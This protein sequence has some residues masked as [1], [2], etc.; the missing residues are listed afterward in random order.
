VITT[1]HA[2]FP[3]GNRRGA[4]LLVAA[5]ATFTAEV[6]VVRLMD[7][8]ASNE[9]IVFARAAVQL[10]AVTAWIAAR[11]RTLVRTGRPWL[12]LARGLTS[13][14]C[15]WLY[16]RSFQLLDLA[17]ATTLTFT[18]SLFVVAL[19]APLLGEKVGVTRWTMTVIGFA[20][21]VVAS[22]ATGLV[23]APG[24]AI[25]LAS[26]AAAAALVFL[27]RLLARSEATS[28]IMLYI[29][30]VATL[31]TLP[32]VV[33]SGLP[34]EPGIYA[35]LALSGALGT[36]GMLLTVEAY[37]VG[38]VSA[39]APFP[40]MRIVFAIAAGLVLFAETP[41][42]RTL[43]GSAIIIG[44]AIAVGRQERPSRAQRGVRRTRKAR[45]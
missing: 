23:L 20:G 33:G 30:L 18:S 36:L 15:W 34:S 13:L 35:L 19:A 41:T 45:K 39:L 7:G 6:V 8:A 16:Y 22:G 25:G 11:D 17:L 2:A 38:E 42:I 9:Q 21:V 32:G 1:A 4:I 10:L 5:A 24:V 14:V 44:S 26:S 12:H 43:A 27:N 29:G 31:G 3:A 28:T 40:Y 37:R